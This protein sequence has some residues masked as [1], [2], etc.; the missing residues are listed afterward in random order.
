MAL[1]L[2]DELGC[3]DPAGTNRVAFLVD[4]F[5]NHVEAVVLA[6]VG[7][8]VD[9]G[10]EDLGHLRCDVVGHAGSISRTEKRTAD[11]ARAHFDQRALGN[12][13]GFPELERTAVV[14]FDNH[15]ALA[16]A[17][18]QAERAQAAVLL[19]HCHDGAARTK[20][21]DGLLAFVRS[22]EEGQCVGV[23][24]AE[25][26]EQGL[27]RIAGLNPLAMDEGQVGLGFERNL[28]R[29]Q[30]LDHGL[31][32]NPGEIVARCDGCC[33]DDAHQRGADD[34]AKDPRPCARKE[35]CRQFG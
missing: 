20:L 13:F 25:A 17:E 27:Q 5:V 31:H 29:R 19:N 12:A 10:A 2:I 23:G 18:G 7:M 4:R 6:Q 26:A 1:A 16:V 22:G 8:E 21:A 3:K 15:A 28:G 32:G 14:A 9:P 30:S 24:D 33:R 35:L 34:A 11:H